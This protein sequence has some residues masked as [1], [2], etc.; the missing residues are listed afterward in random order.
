V[1]PFPQVIIAGPDG[2]MWF[3]ETGGLGGYGNKLGYIDLAGGTLAITE[4]PIPTAD[5]QP[6][7]LTVGP[8]GTDIWFAEV[9]SNQVGHYVSAPAPGGHRPSGVHRSPGAAAIY[10]ASPAWGVAPVRATVP[11]LA[12]PAADATDWRDYLGILLRAHTQGDDKTPAF[13]AELVHV[14]ALPEDVLISLVV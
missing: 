7:G 3:T 6:V 5:S 11:A 2:N 9:H 4:L 1:F 10:L 14:D 13:L 12:T 8:S